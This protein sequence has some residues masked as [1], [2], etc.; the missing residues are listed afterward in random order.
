MTAT[1][2]YKVVILI[3]IIASIL[4]WPIAK[5]AKAD[6]AQYCSTPPF[7]TAGAKPN[8]LIILD[9]SNSMDEDFYGNAVGS[10]AS[11]SKSVVARNALRDLLDHLK[12]QLRSGLMT[13]RLPNR[14]YK[15]YI[16]NSPYFVSYEPKSYC[17]SHNKVCDNNT[18]QTCESDSDCSGGSCVDPCVKYCQTGDSAY[19][20]ICESRCHED[21]PSFNV[22]YFDEIITNYTI[23][24][25]QRNRY[26]RLVYPKM[27]RM[28]NPTDPYHYMYYKHA[29]PMYSSSNLAEAFC[30]STGY[31]PNEGSPYDSYSC[32]HNKTGTSDDYSGYSNY[33]FGATVAPT[34]TDYALGYK[35][36]GRRLSWYYMGRTWFSNTSPGDGYLHVPAGDLVDDAAEATPT[37]N[38]IQNKLDPKENDEIG[39]MSCTKSDKNTCD[40][41]INAGLTPTAGTLQT[42]IDYFQGDDSPIQVRCQKNFAIYVTDGLP[43]VDENGNSNTADELMP[44]VLNK[45]N[46][47]RNITKTIND[48]SYTFDIKTYILGMGFSDEAKAKLDQMAVAGGTDRD[49]HA[50][51]ADN[52]SELESSLTTIFLDILKKVASGTSVSVLSEKTNEG[53]NVFQAVFYPQKQFADGTSLTWIGYLYN[54]WFYNSRNTSNIR[55]DTPVGGGNTGDKKLN[56]KEDYILDF[57]F[58]NDLLTIKKYQDTDGDGNA[59]TLKSTVHHLDDI[60][61]LWETGTNLFERDAGNSGC[62]TASGDTFDCSG[63]TSLDGARNIFT[64]DGTFDKTHTGFQSYL[65]SVSNTEDL[66][67]YVRGIDKEGLR[68][69]TVTIN[70]KTG[71]WKLGDIVYSTPR[72]EKYGNYSVLFVGANDGMLHAFKIGYIKKLSGPYDQAQLCDEKDNCNTT[73]TVGKELWAF[74]PQNTLP[75]LRYLS[76]A[77][78]CHL[79]FADLS[80]YITEI[81]GRTILIGGMRLGGGCATMC[82]QGNETV[83]CDNGRVIYPPEDTCPYPDSASCVGRSSYFALDITDPQKPK[84]LWEFSHPDLGFSYSGPAVIHAPNNKNYVLF[85]SGPTDYRGNSMQNLQAFV[86][87]LD[88]N[89]H[90]S[91]TW[92]HDFGSSYSN[93]FGGRLFTDGFDYNEDGFTDLVFFGFARSPNGHE[94][95]WEGNVI[96]LKIK[97]K[98]DDPTD[99]GPANWDFDQIFNSA[100]EPVIARILTMPCFG[101]EYI[102]FGTGRYFYNNDNYSTNKTAKLYG[103]RI[104]DCYNTNCSVNASHSSNDAC[105]EL[106]STNQTFSWYIELEDNDAASNEGYLKER[107]ISDPTISNQNMVFFT[108]TEPTSDICGFGGRTRMWGFNC[109]TGEAISSQDCPGYVV[110][111]PKGTLLLQTSTGVITQLNPSACFTQEDNRA[112]DWIQ[113]VPPET[114]SPLV[115]PFGLKEGKIIHWYEK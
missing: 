63:C 16:H 55:E 34:D 23:G 21:N 7:V 97:C 19:K 115:P 95:S 43:S 88:D 75:Y 2:K 104:E 50:Y 85:L 111:M 73:S 51:Y 52:P 80:P 12:N 58:N 33:W 32:Y 89:L 64:T 113:G 10:Y 6:M 65:G 77:N 9:N 93:G 96:A 46:V 40:Y 14:I 37:Y 27:Q 31:N 38:N 47:L 11:S 36:L 28:V 78:Y 62:C 74:I 84:F 44:D 82:T 72:L 35:D 39:Y 102:Y 5:T 81:N 54:Y 61:P 99:C 29:Y 45:I 76:D 91:N 70:G 94:D 68:N 15:Y 48:T 8:V 13:Y 56:L 26:C 105:D 110:G 4:A 98:A 108:T 41:I 66:V 101:M 49:G 30:Y 42:A 100:R 86:L 17:P 57:A 25:E 67:D 87:T 59:D 112:S 106:D 92:T 60:Y 53:A 83:K 90:I 114:S 3:L 1:K 20:S 109:A 24:S 107:C 71:T 103:V 69:R 79:Y 22:D 18:S